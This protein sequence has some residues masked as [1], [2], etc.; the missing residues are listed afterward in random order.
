MDK[1]FLNR[2]RLRAIN[3]A[4]V[5]A[6]KYDPNKKCEL[7]ECEK[8]RHPYKIWCTEHLAQSRKLKF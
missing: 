7:P 5:K 4:D 6:E 3:M 8:K 2:L 1:E